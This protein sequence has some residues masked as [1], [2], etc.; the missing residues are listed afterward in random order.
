MTWPARLAAFLVLPAIVLSFWLWHLVPIFGLLPNL[1][2]IPLDKL[3]DLLL[4]FLAYKVLTRELNR[5][6][7]LVP[8]YEV[9]YGS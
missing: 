2:L 1:I 6:R 5:Y 4:A 8:E 3:V 7:D 9:T